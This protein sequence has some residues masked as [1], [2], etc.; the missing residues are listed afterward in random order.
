M[1]N[2]KTI[3]NGTVADVSTDS[4]VVDAY[5]GDSVLA[6]TEAPA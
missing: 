4:A 5:L 2:G 6:P 1:A 3:A